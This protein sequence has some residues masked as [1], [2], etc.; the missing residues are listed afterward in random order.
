[1]YVYSTVN[2]SLNYTMIYIVCIIRGSFH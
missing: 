2:V 1:L